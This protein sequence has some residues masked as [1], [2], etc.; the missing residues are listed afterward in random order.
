MPPHPP[1]PPI[2]PSLLPSTHPLTLSLTPHRDEV[3]SGWG[4]QPFNSP[5]DVVVRFADG[6]VWFTD[7]SYASTQ[8]LRG[9]PVLGEWVFRHTPA[10]ARNKA[11]TEVVADGFCRPNGLVF[12][13]DESILYVTDT[14]Y[15]TGGGLDAANPR[16]IYAFDVTDGGRRLSNRRLIYV[17]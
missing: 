3:A 8:G 9:P 13:P 12:S 17:R 6:S 7:P 14:G 2:H 11:C 5:N 15:A 10:D 16:S 1:T 4:G